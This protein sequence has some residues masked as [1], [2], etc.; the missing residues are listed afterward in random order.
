MID[1]ID[2]RDFYSQRLGI[3]ARRLI[4]RGIHARWPHAQGQRVLGLGYPTPYLGLFRE[5]S[6]RCIAFMPAA[7]GVLKWP[8][9]KPA[10][11]TLVD[12]F[13]LPLP[14]AAVDRVLIV[15]ALEMSDDPEGLLREVW[16]V[17]APSGRVMAIIPN[18]R[19]VW[20]RTD[21]TPFGHGRPIRARRSPSCCGRPGSRRRRGRGA[22]HAAG[23]RRLVPASAMAWERVGAALSL[24]FAGV[25][26]VE[27]TKAGLPRDPGAPRTHAAHS[28][29]GTGAGAVVAAAG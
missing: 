1:V 22:V 17:L 8:T 5:D 24:P 28:V 20:T 7:Q 11:A 26:I 9:A 25:H 16:R 6:E 14:D 4:N 12:E 13:S 3:V 23:R 18:R 29:A 19:G 2:L 27:A 21:N 15:H 10:L